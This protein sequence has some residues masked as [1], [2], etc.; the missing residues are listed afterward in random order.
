MRF[1]AGQ[2]RQDFA[3][4]RPNLRAADPDARKAEDEAVL[5]RLAAA[6]EQSSILTLPGRPDQRLNWTAWR[7]QR[8]TAHSGCRPNGNLGELDY[9]SI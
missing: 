8:Q 4:G 2:F 3:S 5:P 7:R 1:F 9:V 6:A